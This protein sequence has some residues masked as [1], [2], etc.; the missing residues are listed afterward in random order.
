MLNDRL[1]KQFTEELAEQRIKPL[2][3]VELFDNY[4]LNSWVG[5]LI[6]FGMFFM[7]LFF[8]CGLPNLCGYF[9]G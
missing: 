4:H 2:I 8:F 3:N 5:N 6:L 7:A 1:R 9:A